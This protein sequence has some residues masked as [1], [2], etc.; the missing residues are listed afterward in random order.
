MTLAVH[1]D[2]LHR[3]GLPYPMESQTNDLQSID[4]LNSTKEREV[5]TVFV[6]YSN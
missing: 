4:T 6:S 5:I 1:R 2:E 3:R